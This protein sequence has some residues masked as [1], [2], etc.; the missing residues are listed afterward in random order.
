MAGD[1]P[2]RRFAVLVLAPAFGQ[3]EFFLRL[4]HRE[5]ADF[6]EIPGEAG[7][8]RQNGQCSSLGHGS[9]LSSKIH[10]P[11][12]A[13]GGVVP[14]LPEPTA[15]VQFHLRTRNIHGYEIGPVEVNSP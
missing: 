10:A 4:Q 13:A 9:A 15:Q 2:V 5:P 1:E 12:S 3:H 7:F 6:F 14:S 8:A 11:A